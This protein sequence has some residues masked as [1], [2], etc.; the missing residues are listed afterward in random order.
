MCK[1]MRVLLY[2]TKKRA[3]VFPQIARAIDIVVLTSN[4][5]RA[6]CVRFP[7]CPAGCRC[8]VRLGA[9]VL[10][11]LQAAAAVC[12]WGWCCCRWAWELGCWCRCRVL[13]CVRLGAWARVPLRGAAARC[14]CSARLGAWVPLQGATALCAWVLVLLQGAAA[15]CSWELGRWCPCAPLLSALVMKRERR[16]RDSLSAMTLILCPC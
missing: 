14:R 10:V 8:C 12:T 2:T 9:W 11:L 13:C 6:A 1:S 7:A 5:G 15:V 4:I 16:S 3:I